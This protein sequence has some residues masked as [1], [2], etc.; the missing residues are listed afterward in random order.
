MSGQ[1]NELIQI[2]RSYV[3]GE[4]IVVDVERQIAGTQQADGDNP[5]DFTLCPITHA[6]MRDPV[7]LKETGQ[8]YERDAISK[9]LSSHSSDP[10]SNTRI[11]DKTLIPNV[12]LKNAI[13][14]VLSDHLVEVTIF[15]LDG[16]LVP[17]FKIN[18]FR[19]LTVG[20]LKRIIYEDQK[21]AIETQLLYPYYTTRPYPDDGEYIK[22]L[23]LSKLLLV[24]DE[25]IIDTIIF[26]RSE[27]HLALK[28]GCI[29]AIAP[30]CDMIRHN[31]D[32]RIHD[33]IVATSIELSNSQLDEDSG[34][35]MSDLDVDGFGESGPRK[36]IEKAKWTENE[37]I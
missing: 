18:I 26:D 4:L 27:S 19:Y 7:I 28:L 33:K 12:A 32:T 17:V 35:D 11:H 9:W 30:L 14:H 24:D 20:D 2:A 25:Q 21:I 10:L 36:K 1:D 29:T 22:K 37:V 3:G 16:H 15:P 23:Y 5:P 31:T 8:S 13:A 6:I 34:T